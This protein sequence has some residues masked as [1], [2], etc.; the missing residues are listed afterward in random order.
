MSRPHKYPK[1][2]HTIKVG[3]R[4]GEDEAIRRFN[5]GETIGIENY[6]NKLYGVSFGILPINK[7]DMPFEYYTRGR[8]GEKQ[9]F[10]F[11]EIDS[12]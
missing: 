7:I 8:F 12:V 5:E 2:K 6:G 3:K 10:I 4:I 1:H 11:Y 9:V